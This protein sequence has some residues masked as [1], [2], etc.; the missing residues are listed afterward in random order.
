MRKLLY[1]FGSLAVLSF[2]FIQGCR[3]LKNTIYSSMDCDQFNID[4][5]ELRTGIDIPKIKSLHC[6]IGDHTRRASFLVLK[7][8]KDEVAYT[9]KYFKWD[10]QKHSAAGRTPQTEW[11]AT[12]DSTTNILEFQLDYLDHE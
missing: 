7:S 10:G 1:F 3:G 2:L 9:Q 5:I 12:Y 11:T 4:H 8:R 6:E